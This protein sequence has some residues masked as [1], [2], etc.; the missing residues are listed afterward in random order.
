[1]KEESVASLKA[2]D[3]LIAEKVEEGAE[4]KEEESG[5]DA[6]QDEFDWGNN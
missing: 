6:M 3:S 4:K 2:E 5:N 1:M